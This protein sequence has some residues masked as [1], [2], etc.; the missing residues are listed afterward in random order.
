M[1]EQDRNS[2]GISQ[3]VRNLKNLGYQK[4]ANFFNSTQDGLGEETF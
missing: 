4:V 2:V 1:K 3:I